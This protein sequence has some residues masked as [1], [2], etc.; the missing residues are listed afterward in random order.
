MSRMF[1]V[2]GMMM[3]TMTSCMC[4]S[5]VLTRDELREAYRMSL[6]RGLGDTVYKTKNGTEIHLSKGEK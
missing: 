4:R 6:S 5:I 1:I 3:M 2:I